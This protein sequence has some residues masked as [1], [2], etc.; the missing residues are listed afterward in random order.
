MNLVKVDHIDIEPAEAVL[1]LA[2]NGVSVQRAMDIPLFVPAQTALGE[3][4]RTRT[5]PVAERGRHDFLGMAHSVNRRSV[6]PVNAQLER[7]MNRGDRSFVILFAPTKLPARSTDSP[8]A[9]ADW[10]DEQVGV[11][12]LLRFHIHCFESRFHVSGLLTVIRSKH[13]MKRAGPRIAEL[14]PARQQR[15]SCKGSSQRA[16]ASCLPSARAK[17]R[18]ILRRCCLVGLFSYIFFLSSSCNQVTKS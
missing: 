15:P 8:R 2:A 1:A 5:G 13:R 4:V 11:T 6:D 14:Q 17:R 18:S 7:A 9:K 16:R 3:N 10:C 12:E